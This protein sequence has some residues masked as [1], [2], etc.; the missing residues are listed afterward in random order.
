MEIN[1]FSR[2]VKNTI[3]LVFSVS[4]LLKAQTTVVKGKLLDVNGNPSEYALVGVAYDAN[5]NGN[6]F[7][8]CDAKGNYKIKLKK[9]GQNFLIYS[10]P[11]HQP[12][13]V[14]VQN[15]KD[16]EFTINVVLAPYKYLDNFDNVGIE[17]PF[18]NYN[19]GS[20]VK[21]TK[22]KDGTY[23]IEIKSEKN[24]IRYELCNIVWNRTVNA[25]GS[26][27]YVPDS[28]GDY[29]S[30][31]KVTGG[32]AVI[33]FDPSKLLRKD[34]GYKVVFHG[35]SY[36][37]YIFKMNNESLKIQ[38]DA[39]KKL[40]DFIE[41]G[42]DFK[43]FHYDHGNYF[44]EL[45]KKINSKKNQY[46][47]NYL[48]LTYV[49]FSLYKPKEYSLE[50][51]K[52]FFKTIPPGNYAWILV[53]SA[54]Y[55]LRSIFPKQK[56]NELQDK[57]LKECK[58]NNVKFYILSDKLEMAKYSNNT[59]ELKKI[60]KLILND[61]KNLK[62]ARILLKEFPINSKITIGKEI[63][64]FKV[65]SINDSSKI[66]SKQ[67]MLGKIYLIDFWATWC[68]PCIGEMKALHEAYK[69]FKDKGF[70]ILSLSL[71]RSTDAVKKFRKEKWPMPWKNG[72]ITG[73]NIAKKF[74][75]TGIP[76]PIL[77]SAKG[78]IL[79]MGMQ[80]RGNE[81]EKTLAKYFKTQTK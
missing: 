80:L 43:N 77:V 27:K 54:F 28:S 62:E 22:R 19:M 24:E 66:Y 2:F 26:Y 20:P 23:S 70:E 42:K 50:K 68:A 37:Q 10:I 56:W 52:T 55:S 33:V 32:K 81:L 41:K 11:G 16:K 21:M 34:S 17:G 30:V 36:D 78:K 53:P 44:K 49:S 71:D 3:L 75:I 79:A 8:K 65:K 58:S 38:M 59:E 1:F 9:W 12:Q 31:A 46:L 29:W 15:L 18:N 64:D 35:S 4:I 40:H 67:S 63:P 60:H 51:A 74:E 73:T 14:P 47:K 45:L 39:S 48:K 6:F 76:K 7:V 13:R 69:N 72:F 25:P 57:F 61:Y 5:E